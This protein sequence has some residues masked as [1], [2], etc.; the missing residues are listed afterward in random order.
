MTVAA[1]STALPD[2]APMAALGIDVGGTKI[3]GGL[4]DLGDGSVIERR[5]QP[6]MP[7][8]GGE[9]LLDDVAAM[10]SDLAG[11]ARDRGLL[12]VGA[13]VG[14]PELVDMEGAVFTDFLMGWKGR[15]ARARLSAVVPARIDA[16]VRMAALAEARWG[17]GRSYRTFLYITVGTGISSTLVIDGQPYAGA[18]GGALVMASGPV[19]CRCSGC[20]S[21]STY[22]LEEVASGPALVSAFNA[23]AALPARDAEDVTAAAAS[24][25]AV[26]LAV[27]DRA[28]RALAGTLGMLAGALDPQAII[29]GGGLGSAPG[30]YWN[31]LTR[32]FPDFLWPLD[33][34]PLPL[35]QAA[36]G[37][38]AGVIGAALSAGL[39]VNMKGNIA[40]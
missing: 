25:D 36:L 39:H 26:A 27:I 6:T 31:A 19:E 23:Q 21:S 11:V 29:V 30:P 13:G 20:N 8:R 15:P 14:V 24:G 17:R 22:V 40:V 3:A 38:D 10:M 28:T 32:A 2:K 12:L 18:R 9:A 1:T 16:D 34:R 4:V 35:E 7:S 33:P 37:A 5:R